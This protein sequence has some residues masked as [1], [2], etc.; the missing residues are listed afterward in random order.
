MIG[1]MVLFRLI[2]C[3]GWKE[4]KLDAAK[5]WSGRFANSFLLCEPPRIRTKLWSRGRLSLTC[6]R[7]VVLKQ[8]GHGLLQRPVVLVRIL[9][10]IQCLRR[11]AAPYES[12]LGRVE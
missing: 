4:E 12:F 7:R 11:R 5:V 3:A 6:A 2:C 1:F 10:D 9:A 8:L